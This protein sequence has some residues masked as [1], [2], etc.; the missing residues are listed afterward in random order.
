MASERKTSGWVVSIGIIVVVLMGAFYVSTGSEWYADGHL[1]LCIPSDIGQPGWCKQVIDRLTREK[2][3]AEK[4]QAASLAQQCV[5][6]PVKD[7]GAQ[8]PTASDDTETQRK[9]ATQILLRGTVDNT[10][11]IR[12]WNWFFGN[13]PID[14][15]FQHLFVFLYQFVSEAL[16]P[17][18]SDSLAPSWNAYFASDE[19]GAVTR[20]TALAYL[21]AAVF[22]AVLALVVKNTFDW[23]HEIF[24]ARGK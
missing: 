10:C 24:L 21:A 16:N 18:F 8:Q 12:G 1:R 20:R 13:T 22:A 9:L 7:A 2:E 5:P 17:W 6:N 15:A 3:E 23:L 14:H 19:P 4:A 11:S